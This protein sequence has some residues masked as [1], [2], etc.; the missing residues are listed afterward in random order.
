MICENVSKL[1]WLLKPFLPSSTRVKDQEQLSIVRSA[2]NPMS[3]HTWSTA[4]NF[5]A[6]LSKRW[7]I[8]AFP[9]NSISSWPHGVAWPAVRAKSFAHTCN[10]IKSNMFL[11]Q[12]IWHAL[13]CFLCSYTLQS[14]KTLLKYL[15]VAIARK[16]RLSALH[17]T[18]WYFRSSVL[19]HIFCMRRMLTFGQR[20]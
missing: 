13:D 20:R 1:Q 7:V 17:L 8:C 5:V 9:L 10:T 18:L 12:E 4:L 6:K 19:S 16:N 14:S 3:P 15:K 2:I 11:K